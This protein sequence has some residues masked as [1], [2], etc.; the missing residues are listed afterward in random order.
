M[1]PSRVEIKGAFAHFC[2]VRNDWAD[3]ESTA[4]KTIEPVG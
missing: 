2:R 3:P 4:T 1:D